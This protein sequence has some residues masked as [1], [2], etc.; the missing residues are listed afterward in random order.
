MSDW[1]EWHNIEEAAR[2]NG[3]FK[4]YGIYEIRILACSGVPIPIHRFVGVDPYG[5]CY[6]GRSGFRT[7]RTRRMIANRIQEWLDVWHP[8]AAAYES[9]KCL[10]PE[11]GLQV[12]ALFLQ[13]EEIEAA[14]ASELRSYKRQYGELPPFNAVDPGRWD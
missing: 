9:A 5:L 2:K 10:L 13:D 11:H 8:G 7:A 12:R 3:I 14:E 6:I 1:S 4:G